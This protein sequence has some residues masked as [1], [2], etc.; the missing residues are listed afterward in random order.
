MMALTA[1]DIEQINTVIT[2]AVSGLA[3]KTELAKL[4]TKADLDRMEARL[5]L[6]R[7]EARA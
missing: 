1:N 6:R 2:R 3:T 5:A 4:A 7:L